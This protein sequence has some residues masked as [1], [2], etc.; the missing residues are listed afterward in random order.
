MPASLKNSAYP[1]GKACEIDPSGKAQCASP[2]IT[3]TIVSERNF[4]HTDWRKALDLAQEQNK[5]I[6]IGFRT[7]WCGWCAKMHEITF[8][9]SAVRAV[10]REHFI[11][12]SVDA[13]RHGIT[14]AMKY[15]VDGYPHFCYLASDR[16]LIARSIG[17]EP[18]GDYLRRLEYVLEKYRQGA[19][20]SGV[21][22]DIDLDFP[23]FYRASFGPHGQCKRPTRAAVREYIAREHDPLNEVV[24]AIISRF[25]LDDESE[26]AF[27][28]NKEEFQRLFGADE[29][30]QKIDEM[31][32]NKFMTAIRTRDT[33]LVKKI[34]EFGRT[35]I[36]EWNEQKTSGLW[37]QYY[38]E[39][40]DWTRFGES[41][42]KAFSAR[43]DDQ[44]VVALAEI[45]RDRCKNPDI[46]EK[47]LFYMRKVIDIG[48]RQGQLQLFAEL[49][50][51]T[52]K[53]E[54][55]KVYAVRAIET[56]PAGSEDSQRA[57]DLLDNLHWWMSPSKALMCANTGES[58]DGPYP[59]V[60]RYA[61]KLACYAGN[62]IQY[63]MYSKRYLLIWE[64]GK[65][66]KAAALTNCPF[67]CGGK[68]PADGPHR[69]GKLPPEWDH[70]K[71]EPPA[72]TTCTTPVRMDGAQLPRPLSQKRPECHCGFLEEIAHDPTS[73]IKWI[74]AYGQYI[75]EMNTKYLQ[76]GMSLSFCP[77]CCGGPIN[78]FARERGQV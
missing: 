38:T 7:D 59:C 19:F 67:V 42:D 78:Q 48:P 34:V 62:P 20:I 1:E 3:D 43:I 37:I 52:W 44:A 69:I 75:L 51:K 25:D 22:P 15:H 55:S 72:V 10:I 21:T 54:E 53:F 31:F 18:P 45:T 2:G 65:Q 5:L 8:M 41:I 9:D 63:D 35:Q 12:I 33:E 60:C 73:P 30:K 23:D 49:L 29:V 56:G 47:I 27:L 57:R 68:L 40:G 16:R 13:E 64:D 46:I 26:L 6:L 4:F 58:Y 32:L 17:Y 70:V 71:L 76:T 24:F 74:Q 11:P 50:F 39:S 36:A 66:L 28:M 61:E 77:R 14:L